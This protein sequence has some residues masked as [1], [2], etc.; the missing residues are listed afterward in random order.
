MSSLPLLIS[1]WVTIGVLV[2]KINYPDD[3]DKTYNKIDWDMMSRMA[4]QHEDDC[5]LLLQ[6]K[7]VWVEINSLEEKPLRLIYKM[8]T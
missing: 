6:G 3:L 8:Q 2:E 5:L 1:V 7:E 4:K